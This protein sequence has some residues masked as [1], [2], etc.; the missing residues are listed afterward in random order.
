[1][2]EVQW[3]GRDQ[4][5]SQTVRSLRWQ[6]SRAKMTRELCFLAAYVILLATSHIAI[7]DCGCCK[8]VRFPPIPLH[9]V[10]NGATDH[11][12]TRQMCVAAWE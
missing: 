6:R 4:R 9:M 10:R 8:V 5:W 3:K 12:A 2:F 7:S 11:L 1:M